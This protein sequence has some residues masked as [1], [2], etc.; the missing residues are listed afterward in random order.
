[1]RIENNKVSLYK[2][3]THLHNNIQNSCKSQHN[4]KKNKKNSSLW[5]E[6]DFFN[7]PN[8]VSHKLVKVPAFK[9]QSEGRSTVPLSGQ[10]LLGLRIH[11]PHVLPTKNSTSF[12]SRTFF[13][14]KMVDDFQHN[15][16]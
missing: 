15:M 1:M 4:Q 8:F 9:F 7:E 14:Y 13:F 6:V 5:K 3:F 10:Q 11:L 12:L 2:V 16:Y